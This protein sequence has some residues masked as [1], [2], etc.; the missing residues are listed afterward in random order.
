M[1]T[2]KR[3]FG[4]S[5]ALLLG[6]LGV[7][8]LG[9][10]VSFATT[11]THPPSSV[12][13][14]EVAWGGTA[15]ST[16]DEWIELHNP[17]TQ[18]ISLAGWTLQGTSINIALSGN[19]PAEGFF[20]LE[21]TDNTTVSDIPADQ[22]YTGALGNGGEILT[23]R[24]EVAQVIDT[25]NGDGGGWNGGSGSPTF[26]SMERTSPTAADLPANWQSND[27]LTR[28][29]LDAAG[30]PLNGTPKQPNRGWV[31]V[32]PVPLADVVVA[33]SGPPTAVPSDTLTYQLTLSNSGQLTA[34]NVLLT[35]TLPT[36]MAY[37]ADTSGWVAIPTGQQISWVVGDVPTATQHTFL[38]TVTV[39]ASATGNLI[40][41]LTA[42]TTT[43][44]TN[45]ANNNATAQTVIF[46]ADTPH[47]LIDA[48]LY[49]GQDKA[50]TQGDEAVR[51]INVG[52][53]TADLSGWVLSDGATNATIPAGVLL[54]SGAA[55]W[56]AKD[57]AAFE[58]QF[59]YSP[60]LERAATIPVLPQLLGTW[61]GYADTGDEVILRNSEGDVVD[62]LVYK[63][64]DTSQVGWAGTA[65]FPYGV[66]AERGQ[67]LFRK[68]DWATGAPLPDT[69]TAA[70]W[71]QDPADAW[72]GRRVQYPGWQLEPFF[73]THLVTPTAVYTLGMAPDHGYEMFKAHISAA[74]DEILIQTHTFEH[75]G[76]AQDLLSARQRGVSVTILLEGGPPG[77]MANQQKYLC[78]QL[79][80]AEGQCW[81]MVN[82]D[83]ADIYDRYTYLHAKFMLV[84]GEQ[85]LI[86]SENLSPN[87]LPDDD[88]S[89]GTHGRRGTLLSTNAPEVVSY[90]AGVWAADFAPTRYRDLRRYDAT[91][92]PPVGY[93][94]ITTTGGTTYTVRYPTPLTV[95]GSLPVELLH[96][97]ENVTRPDSGLF[98]LLAQAGA[99][100]VVLV[101]QLSERIVWGD[102]T[103][104]R[105]EAYLAAARR[106]ATVRLLLDG[107][108]DNPTSP[109]SNHAT[110]AAL[111]A[112]AQVEGLDMQC[113]TGN[114]TGLGIHN[115]MVL[116]RLSGL[117]YVH[118]GSLNGTETSHK[119]NRELAIQVQSD[120]MYALLAEM[121]GR[122]WRYTQHLPFVLGEYVPPATY[123]L[124]SEL[125][126]DPIG[127][128]MDEFIEL[129]NPT[130]LSIDLGGYSLSDAT[131]ITDFADL[132][133][134]PEGTLIGP[135]QAL[136]VAQQAVAFRTR[137]GFNPDFEILETDAAV[138]NLIDDPVWGDPATFLQFGNSGDIIYLRDGQDGEVDVIAYGNREYPTGGVCAAVASGHS[139]RRRPYWRDVNVCSRDFEDWPSPDPGLLP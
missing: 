22:I 57:G 65:V 80:A 53:A 28:N 52:G 21:R 118:L 105:F 106:G 89:D 34:A 6:T 124:I 51:L 36:G 15:A 92:A 96:A 116:V 103:S 130:S 47:I 104:L 38:L 3:V 12:I 69:N 68:R 14:S 133:R 72:A 33:K 41:Q 9:T 84:D 94:P 99:G 120:E 134:F 1:N 5:M 32:P 95:M 2:G 43:T 107:Y 88:K 86:A 49:M 123:V 26:F 13:I 93:V 60:D 18:T 81:F 8:G 45:L 61:P 40:N 31:F 4:L 119:L 101:Q 20:L 91:F 109:T 55:I 85:V 39:S 46:S 129:A 111:L 117:G 44:E 23:L 127:P 30:N 126:Y 75:W 113:Q 62:A 27:G 131:L 58:R 70:S 82:D 56:L 128:D 100:D 122:D 50:T 24:N 121:F 79:E 73:F 42:S 90:V 67:I 16:A 10:A 112:I 125:L 71:A 139:L 7:L 115:K 11:P 54:P 48:V 64:G 37:V 114:P 110:C 76:I 137:Y 87:S 29:G 108:F 138:P 135:G 97:P 98:G 78:Q 19:I 66:G 132:R 25:A 136:V 74:Q 35:D 102:G 63:A 59:G 83:P 77:G 17:T